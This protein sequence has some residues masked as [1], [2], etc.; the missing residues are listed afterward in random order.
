MRSF[1]SDDHQCSSTYEVTES[2]LQI[3]DE[4][5]RAA[6][7]QYSEDGVVALHG[8]SMTILQVG[9]TNSTQ[10]QRPKLKIRTEGSVIQLPNE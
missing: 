5:A 3:E 1:R 9:P 4:M 6:C 2:I 7:K 10:T 8:T